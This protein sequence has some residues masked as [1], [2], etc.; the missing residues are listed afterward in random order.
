[1]S[2]LLLIYIHNLI[3]FKV[4]WFT[5]EDWKCLWTPY[6]QVFLKNKQL[7]QNVQNIFVGFHFFWLSSG[8]E[9]D[10]NF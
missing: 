8:I 5:F 3:N 6:I 7:S 2:L 9:T 1:M 4:P 10:A